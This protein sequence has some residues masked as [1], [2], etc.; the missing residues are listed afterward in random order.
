MSG[1]KCNNLDSW[2]IGEKEVSNLFYQTAKDVDISVIEGVMGLYDGGREGVSST[3]EIAKLI[4]APVI[5]VINCKSIG[6]SAAA[7]A[8]GFRD[9]DKDMKFAGVILNK[10]G[11]KSHEN[12]IREAMKKANIKVFGAIKRDENLHLPERHLGLLP[13]EENEQK[14]ELV[15]YFSEIEKQLNIDEIIAVSKNVDPVKNISFISRKSEQKNVKI[16]VAKDEAFSFY[17]EDSLSVL[18]EM[19]AE[20]IDF[21]PLYDEKLPPCDG[22]ILGGGFPE[23]FAE[24]LEKNISMR[25]SIKNA[26]QN[27]LPIYAECGGYMY[28]MKSI[29][30]LS[31]KCFNMAGVIDKQAKMQYKLQTVGYVTATQIRDTIFGKKDVK[32]RGHE[33]HFSVADEEENLSAFTMEKMR[34][35]KKYLAGYAK[36]NILGSYLHLHFRGEKEAAKNF[37][38]SC[39]NY[40]NI[41]GELWEK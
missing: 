5:L 41:K 38:N 12:M 40:K 20:I 24:K 3:A 8:T 21:S 2:L 37:I 19:G 7:I 34:T 36:K 9:Y 29:A 13:A 17:Y 1:A 25:D 28:L 15:K 14:D 33:F 4:D 16:A 31:G 10:L 27:G 22:L 11:S 26:A 23:M 32:F 39:L 30:D 18:E 6:A 35:G